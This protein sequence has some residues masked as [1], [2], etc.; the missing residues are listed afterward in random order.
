MLLIRDRAPSTRLLA[1]LFVLLWAGAL[2]PSLASALTIDF[3]Q[4]RHGEVIGFGD[5]DERVTID[6]WNRTRD[7]DLAVV[8]DSEASGTRDRDLEAPWRVGN[9]VDVD[10]PL[11]QMLIIQENDSGCSEIGDICR[12]PDDEGRRPAGWL[13]FGFELPTPFIGFDLI[14]VD[15]AMAERG[16][17]V[18]TD[19]LGVSVVFEFEDLLAGLVIGDNSANRIAPILATDHGLVDIETARFEMGGSGALDNIEYGVVPEPGTAIL[20]GIGL[21]GLTWAGRRQRV[22]RV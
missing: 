2:A 13:S 8:F 21:V 5:V 22:Q 9:L 1:T 16:E 14:D 19:S 4:F 18:L 15:D 20:M 7:F 10:P 17:L 6:V 3:E 12:H 11:G